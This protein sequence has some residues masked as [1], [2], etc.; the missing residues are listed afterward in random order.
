[1]RDRNT[2]TLNLANIDISAN[3][4]AAMK[5]YRYNDKKAKLILS[6]CKLKD[7]HVGRVVHNILKHQYDS[8]EIEE[9][10][11][12]DNYITIEGCEYLATLLMTNK[13]LLKLDVS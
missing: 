13:K 8:F 2:N 9:L 12:S 11:L 5:Y 6:N 4:D 1:M 3:I 7:E 10:D